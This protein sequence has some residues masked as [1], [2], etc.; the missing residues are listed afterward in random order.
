MLFN[1]TQLDAY[2]VFYNSSDSQEVMSMMV[3]GLEVTLLNL[4]HLTTYTISVAAIRSDN[5]TGPRSSE[6]HNTTFGG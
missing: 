1:G 6:V 3:I 4:H 2:T 5:I